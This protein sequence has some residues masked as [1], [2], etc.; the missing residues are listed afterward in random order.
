MWDWPRGAG[1][2]RDSMFVT[3]HS[4][5]FQLLQ[6]I[7]LSS[8]NNTIS[9]NTQKHRRESSCCEHFLWWN[10]M[11]NELGRPSWGGHEMVAN[12]KTHP[13]THTENC[14]KWINGEQIEA[15][16]KRRVVSLWCEWHGIHYSAKYKIKQ[17]TKLSSKDKF[18]QQH[19][20]LPRIASVLLVTVV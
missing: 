17:P 10:R 16:K 1:F 15:K 20:C 3:K 13:N 4:R 2:S 12:N 9:T 5:G 18:S 14:Q 6:K 11:F 8:N 7:L 19:S